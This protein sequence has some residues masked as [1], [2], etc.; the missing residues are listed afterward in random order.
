MQGSS[1]RRQ[2]SMARQCRAEASEPADR[3][4]DDL[5]AKIRD[6]L[7]ESVIVTQG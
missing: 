6:E 1:L 5:E 7:T 4:L 2:V 3:R